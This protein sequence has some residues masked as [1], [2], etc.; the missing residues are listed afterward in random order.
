MIFNYDTRV[1]NF[2]YGNRL[3]H[4]PACLFSLDIFRF[5][6]DIHEVKNRSVK[7]SLE[8]FFFIL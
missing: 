7:Y 2:K 1:Q 6:T 3:K 4:K 5:E 8:I